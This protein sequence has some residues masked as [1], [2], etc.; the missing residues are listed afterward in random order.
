MNE[1]WEGYI[2]A[3]WFDRNKPENFGRP[4]TFNL[5]TYMQV[6]EQLIDADEVKLALHMLDNPPGWYR[7][8]KPKELVE[9]RDRLLKQTFDVYAYNESEAHTFTKQELADTIK[10][11]Q[12]Y[13]RADI[14]AAEIKK[15]NQLVKIPW[16]YELAPGSGWMAIGLQEQGHRFDY[17]GKTLNMDSFRQLKGFIDHW[18]DTPDKDQPTMF[19]CYELLEHLWNEQDIEHTY[20]RTGIEFDQ[21]FLSTPRYCYAGGMPGWKDKAIGHL[22]TW[23]PKEFQQYAMKTWP[24]YAWTFHE[25][26]TMVMVGKKS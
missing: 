5:H 3:N 8:N 15:L 19:V 2:P 10:T 12:A 25:N 11:D 23:T 4:T 6:I 14:L 17:Y 13:P 26:H 9:M 24:G 7:D 21:I 22:R 1:A 18:R 20:K 16:I